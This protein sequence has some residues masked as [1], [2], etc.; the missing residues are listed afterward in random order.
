MSINVIKAVSKSNE[1]VTLQL[2]HVVITE[3][4]SKSCNNIKLLLKQTGYN[5]LVDCYKKSIELVEK[6]SAYLPDCIIVEV[7]SLYS[8]FS[9]N[10]KIEALFEAMP[11]IK[12]ALYYNMQRRYPLLEQKYLQY[13][14]LYSNDDDNTQL[15]NLE[16]LLRK[17]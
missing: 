7:R 9:L 16:L 5:C 8:M 1:Q 6:E 11:G 3:A 2:R 15:K 12:L 14:Q 13:H 17:P 4:T 10:K